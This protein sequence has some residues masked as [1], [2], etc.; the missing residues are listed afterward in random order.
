MSEERVIRG[1][2]QENFH[3]H[4]FFASFFR[5]GLD[6]FDTQV[7]TKFNSVVIGTYDKAVEYFRKKQSGQR[8]VHALPAIALDP[9]YDFG[10]EE[11]GGRFLWQFSR[12]GTTIGCHLFPSI[13]LKE[14]DITVT[15]VFSR[16]QGTFEITMWLQSVYE[17][18]DI[19][20]N[21]L[22]LCGG[23]GRWLRPKYFWSYLIFPDKIS[24]FK[25]DGQPLDWGNTTA[26]IIHVQTINQHKLA[27]P[28]PLDAMWKLDS[29]ADASTKYGNDKTADY[30][31][32][33]TFSY[34]VNLPTY[35]VLNNMVRDNT[36]VPIEKPDN[37]SFTMD[38][39]I[40]RYPLTSP[41]KVIKYFRDDVVHKTHMNN[42]Y[43]LFEKDYVLY[44]IVENENTTRPYILPDTILTY[45]KIPTRYNYIVCG[46]LKFLDE[47]I[48][49]NKFELDKNDILL[50]KKYDKVYLPF[51]RRCNGVISLED[52]EHTEFYDKVV[53]LRKPCICRIPKEN[54]EAI[55]Q[56]IDTP[57]T[58]DP[59][60][61][62]IYGGLHDVKVSHKDDILTYKISEMI[63]KKYPKEYD[64]AL[65]KIPGT[66]AYQA[67]TKV[68]TSIHS[69]KIIADNCD[70]KT[71]NFYL[72]HHISVDSLT[73][74]KI[75]INNDFIAPNQYELTVSN[76]TFRDPPPK[77]STIYLHGVEEHVRECK[78]AA[79]YTF[80]EDD[81]KNQKVIM[82]LPYKVKTIDDF[83]VVTYIGELEYGKEYKFN[84]ENQT[85][86]IL[87]TPVVGEIVQIFYYF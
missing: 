64:E 36:G 63:K 24:K 15:P 45:P 54:Q 38:R 25:K 6:W 79:I 49:L 11:R 42:I 74:C 43:N 66:E 83:S 58:I 76:I 65:R 55:L 78:L 50:I 34:E 68:D 35:T 32:Q 16:Y 18:M 56:L 30:K 53:I 62:Y 13:N 86:E 1:T 72:G 31:M 47:T 23:Y 81:V 84:V 9:M 40:A 70:G 46:K 85:I 33:A 8:D 7:Y 28:I 59:L 20:V 19:R 5:G 48:D 75:Y 41:T 3:V 22:Q 61:C 51:L 67:V 52:D 27:I 73:N 12:Y 80:T 14:Q 87:V 82:Q 77:G 4:G 37:L 69:K 57:I 21:L 60:R 71:T 44:D 26:D 39:T 2:Y 29:C 10:N 17:M